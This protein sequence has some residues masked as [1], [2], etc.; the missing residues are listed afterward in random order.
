VQLAKCNCKGKIASFQSF[1]SFFF[2]VVLFLSAFHG[3]ES[4][5]VTGLARR[6]FGVEMALSWWEDLG[7]GKE[8]SWRVYQDALSGMLLEFDCESDDF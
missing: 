7:V 4:A 8:D 6:V 1:S 3:G 2:R 5:V